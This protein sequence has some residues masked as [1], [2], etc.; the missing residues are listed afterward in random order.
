MLKPEDPRQ[1]E[2]ARGLCKAVIMLLQQLPAQL[3][4][5]HGMWG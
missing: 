4:Q 3:V 2:I 1:F 5:T